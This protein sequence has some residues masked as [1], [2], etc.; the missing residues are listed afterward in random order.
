[1]C[2]FFLS[3]PNAGTVQ[4]APLRRLP[5]RIANVEPH[6][7]LNLEPRMISPD[8]NHSL[9]PSEMKGEVRLRTKGNTS[10]TVIK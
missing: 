9:S 8:A 3:I 7:N 4:L 6:R 10:T 5:L 2:L 1:M